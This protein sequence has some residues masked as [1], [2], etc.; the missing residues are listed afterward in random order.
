MATQIARTLLVTA[1][2]LSCAT[3]FM[4]TCAKCSLPQ[5]LRR[6]TGRRG[7]HIT[8]MPAACRSTHFK[9]QTRQ[10]VDSKMASLQVT[11]QEKLS[12]KRRLTQVKSRRRILK[13]QLAELKQEQQKVMMDLHALVREVQALKRVGSGI[14]DSPPERKALRD[15][16]ILECKDLSIDGAEAEQTVDTFLQ[17]MADAPLQKD[18]QFKRMF[19]NW[20]TAQTVR[21]E[22]ARVMARN[23]AVVIGVF[24][25]VLNK[26][27]NSHARA[28]VRKCTC[29]SASG[30]LRGRL[31]TGWWH[32]TG[33]NICG[34]GREFC[35]ENAGSLH[36][37][38]DK[39]CWQYGAV[40]PVDHIALTAKRCM[41]DAVKAAYPKSLRSLQW[42]DN[43]DLLSDLPLVEHAPYRAGMYT[44]AGVGH[45]QPTIMPPVPLYY[46]PGPY[47]YY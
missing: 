33:H 13:E 3:G 20:L 4:R 7:F 24:E 10:R 8:A 38:A 6:A 17:A 12:I 11:G 16:L 22:S 41:L 34:A 40:Y 45:W 47:G 29:S 15:W 14:D 23:D 9:G 28:G 19:S 5:V 2:L 25:M 31:R 26:L 27:V 18:V 42:L 44:A 30:H 21:T 46:P 36:V 43:I 39:A 1:L 37:A 32:V 35:S